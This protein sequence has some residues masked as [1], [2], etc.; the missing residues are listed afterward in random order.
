MSTNAKEVAH[1]LVAFKRA[2]GLPVHPAEDK[3]VRDLDSIIE[4]VQERVGGGA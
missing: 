1:A 3:L 4:H 2:Q